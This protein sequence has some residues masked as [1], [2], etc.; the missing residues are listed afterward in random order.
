MQVGRNATEREGGREVK[1]KF[2]DF[3]LSDT[4][5]DLPSQ[6]WEDRAVKGL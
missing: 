4:Q 1:E 5:G 6:E 3:G 2:K